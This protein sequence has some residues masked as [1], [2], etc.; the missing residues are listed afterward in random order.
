MARNGE[1]SLSASGFTC[2]VSKLKRKP[3]NLIGHIFIKDAAAY[4]YQEENVK[5]T[6]KFDRSVPLK[7]S[8]LK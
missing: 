1:I 6:S 8:E 7:E 5:I 4:Y 2:I 3:D